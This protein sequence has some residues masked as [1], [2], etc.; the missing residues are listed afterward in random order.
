[1]N[2]RKL[3]AAMGGTALA[4]T[5]LRAAER[6]IGWISPESRDTT[7]PFFRAF[8]AGLQA[9]ASPGSEPIR[10]IERYVEGG[11]QAI[12]AAVAELQREGVS[13]IVAQG[14]ATVPVVQA[15]PSVPVVFGYSGD[16]VV[17]G[18]VPSLARPGGNAT[19]MSFMS[20]ELN[21]KR[22]DL[23]RTALPAAR[24]IALL[25]NERHPG[26]ENEIAA[27]Q[28]AVE[29]I[30]M[31]LT[32][33]RSRQ[34]DDM[35]VMVGRA[36]DSGAQAMLMLPSSFMVRNAPM[37]CAM[38]LAR[39]VPLVSGWAAIA[40]AGALLTYGPN[41]QAAYRR[42]GWYVVRVLGGAAPASL[43]VE[44]PSILELAINQRTAAVLNVTMPGSLLAQADEVIE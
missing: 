33:W 7:L 35:P 3:L 6:T 43:P 20:I 4:A 15:N 36:L 14:G 24:R 25:S 27:C 44:Q 17:A 2:R 28:R 30:G 19:G 8:Q 37:T 1:M 16:P 34:P 9:N 41:L 5:P 26:E 13:L 42:V 38:G 11:P 39:K 40:Q 18:I 23:L 12:A 31:E 29:R 32:V 21:L 22:I 10:V